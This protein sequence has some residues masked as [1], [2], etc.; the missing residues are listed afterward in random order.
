MELLLKYGAKP[1]GSNNLSYEAGSPLLEACRSDNLLAVELLMKAGA[2]PNHYPPRG[3]LNPLEGAASRGSKECMRL[4]LPKASRNTALRGL[5][6]A[7]RECGCD[8]GMLK[9]FMDYV[10]DAVVYHAI[11][12]GFNDLASDILDTGI[13]QA[14]IDR[15]NDTY[16]YGRTKDYSPGGTLYCACETG[17]FE[18][19][20]SLIQEGVDP[21]TGSEVYGPSLAVAAYKGHL[22]IVKML[23]Q[24]GCSLSD[25]DGFYGGPVQAAVQGNHFNVLELL[26]SSGASVNLTPG[27]VNIRSSRLPLSS[28][29]LRAARRTKNKPLVD[30][31]LDHGA[32]THCDDE[33]GA[34]ET[35]I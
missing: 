11:S 30:W 33:P 9:L 29:P 27:K 20:K 16:R 25:G 10:P 24:S 18:M 4:L 8:E 34:S 7:A 14:D 5:E 32:N 21:S 12:L 2:S 17:N 3:D 15:S 28:S 26:V 1:D 13:I 23:I 6:I 31:L 35:S 22:D 19:A